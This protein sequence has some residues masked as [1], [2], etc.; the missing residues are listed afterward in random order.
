MSVKFLVFGAGGLLGR[1]LMLKGGA[2]GHE[3][4]GTVRTP[5][6]KEQTQRGQ[7]HAVDLNDDAAM[8]ALLDAIAPQAVAYAAGFHPVDA[9]ESNAVGAM[10]IHAVLPAVLAAWCAKHGAWMGYVSTDYVFDGEKTGAYSESDK[11]SPQSVYA[12]TKWSGEKVLLLHRAPIAVL[13]TSV[14]YGYHPSKKNFVLWLLDELAAGKKVSVADDQFS[15]PTDAADLAEAILRLAAKKS[16]GLYH[17]A[18]P[19][20]LSRL[21]FAQMAAGLFGRRRALVHAVKTADL[22]QAAPRP[23]N[24]C[25]SSK[26]LENEIGMKFATPQEGLARLRARLSDTD[27]RW[28]AE[29]RAG[30]AEMPPGD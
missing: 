14:V 25:L 30:A 10:R 15:T 4:H 17:A 2:A 13:R 18:G 20:C 8:L 23:A 11:P 24:G 7:Y 12:R 3:M 22:R 28:R 19:T 29:K 5:N 16:G 21:E 27:E 1:E 26:K 9:C 6:P